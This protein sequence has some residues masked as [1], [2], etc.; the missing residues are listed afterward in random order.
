MII[1][2]KWRT[3]HA[4]L[5]P[6]SRPGHEQQHRNHPR[7]RGRQ[8]ARARGPLPLARGGDAA[9]RR[10]TGSRRGTPRAPRSS[11]TPGGGRAR[12]AHP[13]HPRL[14][15]AHPGR[16]RSTGA[17]YYNFWRDAKNPRGLWRRT[18]LDEYRKAE[19]DWET[20][21][22][23][24]AL[25]E[26]EKENWVWH[27]A[28]C[29]QPE[30]ERCL[31]S[32]VARRRRRRRG[33]RVRPRR[34][35]RSS[36]DGFYLPEAKSSVAWSD[37]DTRL[38]RH[39]LRPG[40]ADRR[41]ATRASSRSGSAARRSSEAE[42]RL[43]GQARGRRASP[44]YR[45]HTKGFERDFV[46][47]RRHLLHERA[48]PA[49]RRQA[50]QD[51]QAR[52]RQRQRRTATCCC[53]S[54]ATTG[55]SAARPIPAGA[56][57]AADFEALPEGQARLRRAVRADRARRRWPGYS[58]TRNHILLNELDN[59]QQPRLRA[60]PARTASGRASRCPGMPEFGTRRRRRP[61]TRT[62]RTTT[63]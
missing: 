42:T 7:R 16:R 8:G 11:P 32:A 23:L 28:D 2:C 51:R 10:S 39:R 3:V 48:V 59:V 47:A 45:D 61:S 33:P 24:D 41:R 37:A 49:P 40:L 6:R 55:R 52:R 20:V 30:Y 57:L 56:L 12:E 18:T 46:T 36:K 15:G 4:A 50:G 22:D 21:L 5:R 58:P 17:C 34:R 53:S 29:L 62:S 27:G 31:I 25:G 60:R 38:R 35:R 1:F 26:A 13:R 19:P 63:S 54:C 14:E 43:R 44:R 9:T